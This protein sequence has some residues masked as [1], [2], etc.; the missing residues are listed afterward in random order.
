MT[1]YREFVPTDDSYDTASRLS[2]VLPHIEISKV[3]ETRLERADLQLQIDDGNI[4]A[5]ITA[6]EIEQPVGLRID[7]LPK[8]ASDNTPKLTYSSDRAFNS[9]RYAQMDISGRPDLGDKNLMRKLNAAFWI[10]ILMTND[11]AESKHVPLDY[12]AELRHQAT[13]F[14]WRVALPTGIG[15]DVAGNVVNSF[16]EH[17]P[18]WSVVN[19][20][21]GPSVIAGMN[22]H[23]TIKNK[24]RDFYKDLEEKHK[25][26]SQDLSM[27]YPELAYGMS[28]K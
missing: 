9:I 15:V 25:D 10:G 1:E 28:I 7:A 5:G 8:D 16:V 11:L 27:R 6:A 2:L 20:L 17:I 22:I 21:A 4:L 3:L 12:R 26:A 13:R 24:R 18:N 23:K 19:I 14:N